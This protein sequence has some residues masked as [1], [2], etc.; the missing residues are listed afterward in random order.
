MC[1]TKRSAVS[2]LLPVVIVFGAL[3]V[4]STYIWTWQNGDLPDGTGGIAYI[5]DTGNRWPQQWLFGFGLSIVALFLA[6]AGLVRYWQLEWMA[7]HLKETPEENS[8]EPRCCSA[9][10]LDRSNDASLAFI[11][12]ACASLIILS[13]VNDRDYEWPHRVFAS[14]CFISLTLYQI[15]HTV[16]SEQF[17][18]AFLCWAYHDKLDSNLRIGALAGLNRQFFYQPSTRAMLA[19]YEVCTALSI[20]A[21]GIGLVHYI[22]PSLEGVP[23]AAEWVLAASSVGYFGPFYFELQNATF[24]TIHS[25]CRRYVPVKLDPDTERTQVD[26][27]A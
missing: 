16:V 23:P 17:A 15:L 20:T 14:I 7:V 22:R 25:H 27:T 3:V 18:R 9:P 1:K 4:T 10:D 13:W 26:S 2:I 8:L 6:W 24:N 21:A 11:M 12:A 5:S 19:W